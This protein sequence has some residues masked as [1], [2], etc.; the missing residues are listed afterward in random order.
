MWIAAR[1]VLNT[2]ELNA[3]DWVGRYFRLGGGQLEQCLRK[4]PLLIRFELL[5]S[6]ETF[7]FD[8]ACSLS[9]ALV[10]FDS[11]FIFPVRSA[12]LYVHSSLLAPVSGRWNGVHGMDNKTRALADEVIRINHLKGNGGLVV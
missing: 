2:G 3:G 6:L 9:A 7:L 8:H 4:D 12:H 11:H 1:K 10:S 5:I